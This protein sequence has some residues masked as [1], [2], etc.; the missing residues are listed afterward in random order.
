[1]HTHLSKTYATHY[2]TNNVS[3]FYE[4]DIYSDFLC[5]A[6]RISIVSFT[7][8]T[9]DIMYL[10]LNHLEIKIRIKWTVAPASYEH[11]R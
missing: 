6:S 2:M 5:D 11:G 10:V 7:S 3:T 9:T 8:V 1:M 4:A